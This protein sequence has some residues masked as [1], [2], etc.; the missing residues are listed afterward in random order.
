MLSKFLR[1]LFYGI[2]HHIMNLEMILDRFWNNMYNF[3]LVYRSGK[4]KVDFLL[5]K[6]VYF[7]LYRSVL[8]SSL[9][10]TYQWES[11]TSDQKFCLDSGARLKVPKYP[12][13]MLLKDFRGKNDNSKEIIILDFVEVRSGSSKDAEIGTIAQLNCAQIR[14]PYMWVHRP[15]DKNERLPR[16]GPKCR[17][18]LTCKEL[19]WKLTFLWY[20]NLFLDQISSMLCWYS[21]IR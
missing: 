3:G 1:N 14:E 6:K 10:S 18:N 19:K 7:S 17:C 9:I 21:N 20:V 12:W 16:H 13:P 5:S 4:A 11:N 15:I 2:L 8:L